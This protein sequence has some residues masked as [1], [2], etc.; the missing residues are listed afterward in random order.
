MINCIIQYSTITGLILDALGVG[1]LLYNEIVLRKIDVLKS[2]GVTKEQVKNATKEDWIRGGGRLYNFEAMDLANKHTPRKAII[3]SRL[4][5][6][7]LMIG[8]IF[9]II[10]SSNN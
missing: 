2:N 10:G 3:L 9:Q 6:T 1:I 8:F 4:G 7:L 5:L